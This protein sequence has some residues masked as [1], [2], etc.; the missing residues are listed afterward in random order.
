MLPVDWTVD[1]FDLFL[2]VYTAPAEFLPW[3]VNWYG[4]AFDA[5]WTEGMQ[6]AFL[7]EAGELFALHGTRRA[8]AR[9]IELYTGQRPEIIEERE[10]LAP[11]HFVVKLHQRPQNE[12][13]LKALINANKPAHTVYLLEY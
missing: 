9:L 4:I 7:A 10:G 1:N 2:G 12:S 13:L 5:S 11:Y 6:R 3:L 8:M